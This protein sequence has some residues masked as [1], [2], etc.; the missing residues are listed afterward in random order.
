MVGGWTRDQRRLRRAVFGLD[1]SARSN[2]QPVFLCLV[3]GDLGRLSRDSR[4]TRA[5]G[6]IRRSPA[7]AWPSMQRSPACPRVGGIPDWPVSGESA[8][9]DRGERL[10]A[11]A[12]VCVPRASESDRQKA[13]LGV[14]QLLA[15]RS[16]GVR[17]EPGL[18]RSLR[19]L[20]EPGLADVGTEFEAWHHAEAAGRPWLWRC[21]GVGCPETRRFQGGW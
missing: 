14:D 7:Q 3:L 4:L 19:L 20:L 18:L 12:S 1:P 10:H 15:L 2:R 21:C 16:P 17:I 6:R 5:L 8:C 9:W 13:C 11:V